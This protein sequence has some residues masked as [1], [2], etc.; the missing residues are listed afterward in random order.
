MCRTHCYHHVALMPYDMVSLDPASVS[1]RPY[2]RP[3][4]LTNTDCALILLFSTDMAA[5]AQ[6]S[7]GGVSA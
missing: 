1:A 2:W 7:A 3:S 6:A 5:A 4:L